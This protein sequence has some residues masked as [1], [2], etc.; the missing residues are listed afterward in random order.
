M[1]TLPTAALLTTALLAALPAAGADADVAFVQP[2][3]FTDVR[4]DARGNGREEVLESLHAHLVERAARW[5]PADE[6]LEVR[7]SD[8]D[9]AGDFEP[10]TGA[11]DDIR[12]FRAIDP[13]RVNLAFR[14]LAAD[15][16]V[17]RQGERRL[18]DT[19]YLSGGDVRS[20]DDPLRFEKA[21]LDRWMSREFD[22]RRTAR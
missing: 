2:G 5:L 7:V 11:R 6:K 8:V 15:G 4:R 21:L 10:W 14:L 13:P 1:R 9:M 17:R 19:S 16:S 12:I 22:V 3:K 20:S 18:V